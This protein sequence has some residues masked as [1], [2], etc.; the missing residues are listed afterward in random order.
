MRNIGPPADKVSLA[1]AQLRRWIIRMNFSA[2]QVARARAYSAPDA[3]CVAR[4]GPLN[5]LLTPRWI[6]QNIFVARSFA[7]G[8]EGDV[9]LALRVQ[10][11]LSRRPLFSSHCKCEVVRRPSRE[12]EY[13]YII[14]LKM[15][16]DSRDTFFDFQCSQLIPA[17]YISARRQV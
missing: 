9:S 7:R 11:S 5:R 6:S 15:R 4:G 3:H 14:S 10:L 17:Y 12:G 1:R 8:K 16:A 13:T 2:Q